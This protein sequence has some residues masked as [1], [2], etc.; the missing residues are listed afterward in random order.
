MKRMIAG[1]LIIGGLIFMYVSGAGLNLLALLNFGKVETTEISGATIVQAIQ[2]QAKLETVEMNISNDKT[3]IK[4]HGILNR[5]SEKITYLAYFRVTA[6]VDLAKITLTD[7]SEDPSS[8]PKTFYITL[9]SAEIQHSELDTTQSRVIAESY[10]RWQ[11]NCT[12]HTSEMVV[13]AQQALR[14][15]AEA[16]A[17]QQNITAIAEEHARV[18]LQELLSN[19]GITGVQIRF[20]K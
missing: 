13:E 14:H 6:G 10:P 17:R 15:Q 11:P 2:K 12:R 18:T 9:P 5:C 3:I 19:A 8:T 7:I 1:T 4:E 16:A 20:V